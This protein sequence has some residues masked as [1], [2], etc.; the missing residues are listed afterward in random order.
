MKKETMSPKQPT[1]EW[2]YGHYSKK[3]PHQL[4]G[5]NLLDRMKKE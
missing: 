3:A 5:K 4:K 1:P 2:Q